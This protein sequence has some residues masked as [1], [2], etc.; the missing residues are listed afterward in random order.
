MVNI[1]N[2][3]LGNDPE[4]SMMFAI[5]GAQLRIG[6]NSLEPVT[7]QAGEILFTMSL[8][9]NSTSGNGEDGIYFSLANDPLNEL[10]DDYYEVISNAVLYVDVIKTTPNGIDGFS[11]ANKLTFANYPNPFK[12]STNFVYNLPV[13]GKVI[14][15]IFDMVGNKIETLLNENQYMGRHLISY[16]MNNI[17]PGI[18]TAVVTVKKEDLSMSRSIKLICK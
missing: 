1:Q 3:Y 5:Y 18:Y 17:R 11:D 7:L 12:E 13:D 8:E 16:D 4:K 6:W 15:E 10:A 2:I 14:L 9:I